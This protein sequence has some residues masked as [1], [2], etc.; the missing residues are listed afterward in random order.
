MPEG[1]ISREPAY[2]DKKAIL[3]MK[4]TTMFGINC[5]APLSSY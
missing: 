2:S 3:E 4:E 5:V 1:T